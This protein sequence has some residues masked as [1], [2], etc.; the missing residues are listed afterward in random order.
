MFEFRLKFNWSLFLRVQLTI[1]QHWFWWWLGAVQAP[2]H[3]LNQW[4]LVYWRMY[5]SLGINELTNV[6][7]NCLYVATPF[8]LE[9]KAF[10]FLIIVVLISQKR[11]V[12]NSRKCYWQNAV[13][14]IGGSK[15]KSNL[16]DPH[17]QRGLILQQIVSWCHPRANPL[18][19]R[20]LLSTFVMLIKNMFN[21][22][23]F[24]VWDWNFE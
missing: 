22:E 16:I 20:W 9:V 3:Y 11:Q 14:V 2:S 15:Q 24:V 17:K 23:K 1:F 21:F 13:V 8:I 10:L 19:C 6:W 18:M 4:W 12:T 5:A 7:Q